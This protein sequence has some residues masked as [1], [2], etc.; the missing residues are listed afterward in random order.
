[1]NVLMDTQAIIWF[2]E[3][4]PQLSVNARSM[5]ENDDNECFFSM[6]SFWE[7]SIKMS[8]GKLNINNLT[9]SQFLDEVTE[10][11]F[12][13]LDIRPDHVVENEKL[14]LF[15]RD[16]FDRLIIAQ[17]ISENMVIISSDVAFD[18]YPIHRIW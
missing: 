11:G 8:L 15:H 13:T 7:I 18:L 3:N 17:A 4:N 9:L 1:M 10:N 16:P 6:A 5:I 2:A 14:P 12:L